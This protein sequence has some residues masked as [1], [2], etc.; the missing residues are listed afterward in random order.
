MILSYTYNF[1][2]RYKIK[3][4]YVCISL[5][6]KIPSIPECLSKVKRNIWSMYLSVLKERQVKVRQNTSNFTPFQKKVLSLKCMKNPLTA[7]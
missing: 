2:H 7:P 5:G 4:T 3:I 6:G 1:I